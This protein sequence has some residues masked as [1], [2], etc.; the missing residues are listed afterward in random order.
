[1]GSKLTWYR[2]REPF[3]YTFCLVD[4]TAIFELK[5]TDPLNWAPKSH[6]SK[7]EG[8]H[9]IKCQLGMP[10]LDILLLH[11]FFSSWKE[12]FGW[13]LAAKGLLHIKVKYG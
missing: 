1:M 2:H 10:S 13:L 11:S 6:I 5:V 9:M 3:H 12:N 7:F 8:L 4:Q